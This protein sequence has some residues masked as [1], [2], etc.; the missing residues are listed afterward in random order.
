MASL[1]RLGHDG[2]RF[3]NILPVMRFFAPFVLL[4]AAACASAPQP[5]APPAYV[6]LSVET[7]EYIRLAEGP[8][9]GF[10]PVYELT[11]YPGGQYV[12][13][14]GRFTEG[15]ERA[16]N[17]PADDAFERAQQ[18]LL[19]GGFADLPE[20]ITPDNPDACPNVATDLPTSE[21]TIGNADGYY[22]TVTYYQGCFVDE[23]GALL[24]ELRAIM[25]IADLVQASPPSADE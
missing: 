12:L 8:C 7:A 18:A 3:A 5:P 15:D 17:K 20:N 11:L 19:D 2:H 10:C 6:P 24:E 23:V 9:F 1:R 21:I 4:L 25:R 22:R 16:D 13:M 14:A